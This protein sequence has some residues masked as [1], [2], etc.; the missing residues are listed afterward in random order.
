RRFFAF[1]HRGGDRDRRLANRLRALHHVQEVHRWT[2][3]LAPE[4][5]AALARRLRRFERL[6]ERYGVEDYGL[7]VRSTPM[8]VLRFLGRT[9]FFGLVVFPLAAWAIVNSAVPY[10]ATR[11]VARAM[12]RGRDQHDT[13][14]MLLGIGFFALFWGGQSAYVF[15]RWGATP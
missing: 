4:E 12:A 10:L 8:V 7:T 6:C 2:R 11:Y 1:R 15:L 14:K 3:E 5:T 9:L 13:A